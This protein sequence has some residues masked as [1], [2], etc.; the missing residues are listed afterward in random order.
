MFKNTAYTI[1]QYADNNSPALDGS[2]KSL[3]AASYLTYNKAMIH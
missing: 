2:S 1:S 3:F